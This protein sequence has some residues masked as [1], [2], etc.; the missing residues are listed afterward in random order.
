MHHS[1]GLI[2]KSTVNYKPG[3]ILGAEVV[4]SLIHFVKPLTSVNA[5]CGLNP[6]MVL[7]PSQLRTPLN[8]NLEQL[9]TIIIIT[10]LELH[11][12]L[13]KVECTFDH[14]VDGLEVIE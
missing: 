4:V 12:R 9:I 11:K 2:N 6:L 10:L 1:A 3:K 14:E 7:P 5:L 13:R 8:T